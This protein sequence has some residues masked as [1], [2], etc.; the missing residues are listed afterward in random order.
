M[1]R[2]GVPSQSEVTKRFLLFAAI[3]KA[4][5]GCPTP[6]LRVKLHNT[7]RLKLEMGFENMAPRREEVTEE[8]RKMHNEELHNLY[9]SPDTIGMIKSRMRRGGH[10]ARMGKM[11]IAY[12]ERVLHSYSRSIH[13]YIY[14]YT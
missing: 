7:L 8:W 11:R 13:I 12:T 6:A 9:C 1:G 2:S 10:V 5:Q 14:I 4:A 3:T